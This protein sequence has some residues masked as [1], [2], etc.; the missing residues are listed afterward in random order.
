MGGKFARAVVLR[1]NKEKT[2]TGL[3]K[4]DL[5]N[6]K[7]KIVSKKSSA[8]AKKRYAS[9]VGPWIK[10]VKKARAALKIKGFCDQE[11]LTTL[12]QGE[13]VLYKLRLLCEVS[14]AQTQRSASSRRGAFYACRAHGASIVSRVAIHKGQMTKSSTP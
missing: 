12:H 10:A 3:T 5:R 1:G 14:G 13:G 11:G 9:T 2:A 4:A 8:A 7:G 6:K